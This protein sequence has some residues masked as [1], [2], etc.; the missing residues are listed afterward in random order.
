MLWAAQRGG[1]PLPRGRYTAV[2]TGRDKAGNLGASERVKV[3]V[4]DD[5]LV[6]RETTTT[7]LAS[8]LRFGPCTYSSANGCGDFPDCGQVVP[9][10]LYAVG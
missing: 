1:K 8:E 9:S 6:W 10:T 4:S 5:Q 2:V 7:V 3:W